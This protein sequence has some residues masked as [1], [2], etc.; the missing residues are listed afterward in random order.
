MRHREDNAKARRA[1]PARPALH[2]TLACCLAALIAG[3]AHGTRPQPGGAMATESE[4]SD[5]RGWRARVLEAA[6]LAEARLGE[7]LER[8][9]GARETAPLPSARHGISLVSAED[10]ARSK[11]RVVLLVHGLDEPGS[12]W[13]ELIPELHARGHAVARFDYPN[14]QPARASADLL[15]G[16]LRQIRAQGITQIDI[17]A[18][19]MGGLIALDVLTRIEGESGVAQGSHLSATPARA[20]AIPSVERLITLGTPF[21]GSPWARLRAIAEIRDHVE[22]WLTSETRDPRSLLDWSK[23]G[24]GEAG[25]DLLPGSP[26]LAE[27]LARPMPPETPAM[28]AIIARLA[29]EDAKLQSPPDLTA[30]TDSWLLRRVIG[31][32]D[33]EVMVDALRKAALEVGDGVVP[34][35]SARAL[36]I[37]DSVVVR[38]DHRSMIHRVEV[39]ERVKR[40]VNGH[41]PD[42]TPEDVLPPAIPIILDRL[43]R[44]VGGEPVVPE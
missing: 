38:S 5:A 19:S 40:L 30:L 1:G 26:Y 14:D 24:K 31:E 2:L 36:R 27:L 43:D 15:L 32:G 37:E 20:D 12:I 25:L 8:A 6:D 33:L 21:G 13:D 4:P 17:V 23:D 35:S 16:E 29:P 7:L 22:R 18:H 9:I 10:L 28:T 34:E 41:S 44:R 11:G 42:A 39:V 3:P